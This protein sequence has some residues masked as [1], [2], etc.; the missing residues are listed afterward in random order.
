MQDTETYYPEHKLQYSTDM[1]CRE[2][3]ATEWDGNIA[4]NNRNGGWF[5]GE[6][7]MRGEETGE[8]VWCHDC[9]SWRE[10]ISPEE[11]N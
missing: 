6:I 4:Y 2:C 8:D 10:L 9:E 1:V 5:Y 7:D 11:T 3:G